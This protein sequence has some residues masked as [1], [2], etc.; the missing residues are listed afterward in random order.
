MRVEFSTLI[1]TD[2]HTRDNDTSDTERGPG[3]ESTMT[4]LNYLRS[5]RPLDFLNMIH[6]IVSDFF[7]LVGVWRCVLSLVS[8]YQ[9][10]LHV[11]LG[12]LYVS[13]SLH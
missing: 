1:P 13:I 10:L 5:N 9:R 12:I 4:T 3:V 6:R 2:I 11:P 7:L 8:H